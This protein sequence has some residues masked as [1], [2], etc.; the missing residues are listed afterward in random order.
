MVI[1]KNRQKIIPFSAVAYQKKAEKI[2]DFL[3]YSNFD[4]G[5]LLTTNRTIQ[6]YNQKFRSKNKPTDILSFPYHLDAKA[7]KKIVVKHDDDK[8]LGDIIIS[9]PYVFKN[10]KNLEGDFE[11]RMNMMLVHGVCHLLGH[12]HDEDDDYKK[13]FTL[14]IKLLKLISSSSDMDHRLNRE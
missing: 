9:L 13:M 2:L 6:K 14:E 7:G 1:V 5:I 4:L 12:D 8:N 11:S 3:G 10:E